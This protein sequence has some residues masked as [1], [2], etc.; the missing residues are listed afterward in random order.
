VL[1]GP[2]VSAGPVNA[3]MKEQYTESGNKRP[4]KNRR[5]EYGK[6]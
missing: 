2:D 4:E 6:S 5:N 3:C 1:P